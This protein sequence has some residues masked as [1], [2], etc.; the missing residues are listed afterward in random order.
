[1]DGVF[2]GIRIVGNCLGTTMLYGMGAG[3]LPT[4]SAVVSDIIAAVRHKQRSMWFNSKQREE[5][6]Q[7][8]TRAMGTKAAGRKFAALISVILSM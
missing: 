7:G 5:P 1:M 6:Y 3:K 4:A 2:N 8:L